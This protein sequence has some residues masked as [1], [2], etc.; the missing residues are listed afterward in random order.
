[1]SILPREFYGR[2]TITVARA[3]L[4]KRIVRR[5]KRRHVSAVITETEAYR[6]NDDPA[7]HAFRGKTAR[8]HVMFEE[9][10]RAYV[11]FT[12]GMHHCFNIVAR[13]SKHQAGAV[14]IRAATPELGVDI[15]LRNRNGLQNISD[16]PAK[17][18]QA[19]AI[20][21]EQYG[22]DLT[23]E[24]SLYIADGPRP[25]KI[26]AG[27]RVGITKAVDLLWNFKITD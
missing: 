11:Y 14:L 4:G 15:M 17:L 19:L 16:G 3:L 8:N 22:A 9:V 1:M 21:R 26:L 2:D 10:G 18:S 7:S 5:I 13:D 24:S 6:H 20:T 27:P 12:Y 23:I 25:K